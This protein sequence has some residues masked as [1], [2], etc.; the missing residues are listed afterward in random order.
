MAFEDF[1]A[2][3]KHADARR[4]ANFVAGKNQK[5]AA[6]LLHV[7]RQMPGAL[8]GVHQ[9]GH[10]QLARAFAQFR[11]GIH[12]SQRIGDV[13]EREQFHVPGEQSIQ[14]AQIQQALVAGDRQINQLR[15]RA[16][17]EQL[18]RHEVAVVLHFR[19]QN[20]VAGLDVLAAPRLRH[21]IDALGR[22]AR[23]NDF[24]VASSR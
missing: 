22:A 4:P 11:H 20:L 23:E 3:P 7:Q 13:R 18:P 8:G 16:F 9:R 17:R 15:A 24:V 2:A 12:R 14:L 1:L 10:A 5:I 19:E 6:D 21:E